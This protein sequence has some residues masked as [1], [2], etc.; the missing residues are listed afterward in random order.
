MWNIVNQLGKHDFHCGA[1]A[2]NLNDRKL[3]LIKWIEI[4]LV[5]LL[6]SVAGIVPRCRTKM[7]WL[8]CEWNNLTKLWSDKTFL[9]VC[10]YHVIYAFYSNSTLCSCL[11]VKEL[12]A[13]NR[14][15][16]LNLSNCNGNWFH[17]HLLHKW[18][19]NHLAPLETHKINLLFSCERWTSTKIGRVKLSENLWF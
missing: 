13:R 19:M 4:V 17:N 12:L 7:P 6:L 3:F 1:V 9:T 18:T 2:I 8:C 14:R 11:N 10:S 15:D 16:I 5:Q